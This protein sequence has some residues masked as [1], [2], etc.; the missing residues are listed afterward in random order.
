MVFEASIY[1]IYSINI[2]ERVIEDMK[3]NNY[4]FNVPILVIKE[5][6]VGVGNSCPPMN[7][8]KVFCFV[9]PTGKD[10]LSDKRHCISCEEGHTNPSSSVLKNT[11]QL[12]DEQNIEDK[13]EN[14][15]FVTHLR[16]EH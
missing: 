11:R 9:S 16:N 15:S 2:K 10:F 14:A 13:G 5:K 4:R 3:Q 12:H 6:H 1:V 7:S 8:L